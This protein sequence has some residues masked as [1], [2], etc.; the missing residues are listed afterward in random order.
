MT[1][2]LMPTTSVYDRTVAREQHEKI[3]IVDHSGR[4]LVLMRSG[5]ASG[6][7]D[8]RLRQ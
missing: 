7:N 2:R 6:Q 4:T 3:G 1:L 5:D 8:F